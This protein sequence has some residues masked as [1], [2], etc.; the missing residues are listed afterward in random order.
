[1]SNAPAITSA[2]DALAILQAAM[3]YLAA[4]D[5]AQMAAESRARALSGLERLDGL[6]DRSRVGRP[7]RFPPGAGGAGQSGRL[8]R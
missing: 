2:D 1:M 3:V 7:R 8:R 5:P 4:A 6:K